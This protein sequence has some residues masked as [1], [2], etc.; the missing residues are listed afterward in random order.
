[1]GT[2]EAMVEVCCMY[3]QYITFATRTSTI[4]QVGFLHFHLQ[5][6]EGENELVLGHFSTKLDGSCRKTLREVLRTQP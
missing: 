3:G 4:Q 5:Q 2:A 6:E 1:M